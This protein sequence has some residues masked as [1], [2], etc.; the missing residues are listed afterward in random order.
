MA[1]LACII[2]AAG[3]GTRMKSTT[4][5]VLHEIAGR[6]MLHH[7]LDTCAALEPSRVVTVVGSGG[8]QV[9]FAVEAFMPGCGIVVQEPQLGTGHAVQVAEPAF[10]GTSVPGD[11]L[12]LYGDTPLIERATLERMLAARRD[13]AAVVV[14]GFEPAEPGAY[15]RLILDGDGRLEAIVEAKD[16]TPDQ[17][18]VGLCNSGVMAVSGGDLFGL[19]EEIDND[20]AKG[21]YYLTDIVAR[22]RSRGLACGVVRADPDEVMGVNARG[23][24]AVAERIYQ[25]RRRREAMAA[26][27]TLR[28]PASVFFHWDT[29]VEPDVVIA[30]HVVFGPGVRV[31]TG[32][33]LPPFSQIERATVKAVRLV[34]DPEASHPLEPGPSAS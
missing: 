13:G 1:D 32:A 28:D 24:L 15:G 25:D 2:L 29:V 10:K 30:P 12:I 31:E 18:A 4:P 11:V 23:E 20:N 27:V 9:A 6:P 22:A 21:E 8:D 5:K 33:S 16:A 34:P 26:G 7:V 3:K 19:L 17:L 14:L